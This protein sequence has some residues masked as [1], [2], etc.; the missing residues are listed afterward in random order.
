MPGA[1]L[2]LTMAFCSSAYSGTMSCFVHPG[3]Y[4]DAPANG[5]TLCW[6]N[7]EL[8]KSAR[9]IE[10]EM[11]L[12]YMCDPSWYACSHL[13][14]FEFA[15][16]GPDGSYGGYQFVIDS[17]YRVTPQSQ[18]CSGASFLFTYD[19]TAKPLPAHRAEGKNAGAPCAGEC[20]GD[21]VNAATGNHYELATDYVGAGV[22]PLRFDRHYNSSLGARS[23]RAGWRWN[24]TYERSVVEDGTSAAVLR[25]TGRVVYFEEVGG[26]WIGDADVPDRL[27]RLVDPGGQPVGWTYVDDNDSVEIYDNNGALLSIT[28]REGFI[29]SLT[30]DG[31]DRLAQVTG[32]FGRTLTFTYD[33]DG[34]WE[35]MT[36]PAGNVYTYAYNVHGNLASVTYPD[37]TPGDPGD[38]PSRHYHYA[39]TVNFD[40]LTGITDENGILYITWAYDA[41]GR[42]IA[43]SLAG[44]ADSVTLAYDDVAG[45]TTLTDALGEV[46]TF[47]FE[48]IH[49]R[50]HVATVSGAPCTTGC[51]SRFADYT[52]DAN[53]HPASRTD[54]NG[55]VTTLVYD[56]R[57]LE[58]SR[59]EAVGSPQERT[60][61]TEWHAVLRLP[62]LVTEPGK[63][64]AFTYDAQGRLLTRTETDT[65]SGN[66]RTRTNTYNALGLV[67]THDGPRNDV[68][69]VTTIDYD[70]QGNVVQS[71]NALGHVS[72]VTAYDPHGHPLTLVDAN[73]LVTTL[74]YD[75][76]RRLT[77]RDVGGST[78][79]F[80]YD[81]VGNVIRTILPDGSALFSE[82]DDAHRLV[83]IEDSL[84]NRTEFVL[85][86]AGN[87]VGETVKDSAASITRTRTR[88][89]NALNRLTKEIGGAG[90]VVDFQ[91]DLAGNQSAVTDG[92]GARTTREYDGLNRLAKAIDPASGETTLGYDARDNL[93]SV[94]D[95]EGLTTTYVYNGLDD[96]SSQTSPDTGVTTFT[97]DDA[98]NRL[99][100]VDA[101]GVVARSNYDA[102]N[103]LVSITYPD[104]A[105]NIDFEYDLGPNGLGR[106]TR[107]TD[108]SGSTDFVYDVRGNLLSEVRTIDAVAYTTAYTYDGAD[109]VLTIT[110]PSGTV[111]TYARDALGRVEHVTSTTGGVMETL[112][113]NISYLPFGP[114]E[115]FDFGNGIP[116]ARTFDQDYRLTTQIAGTVQNLALGY[117]HANNITTL[118]DRLDV[119]RSQSFAYD[120]LSRLTHGEG[121]Y[122]IQDYSYD[123]IGN[124]LTLDSAAG[125]DTYSYGSD[126]H[127]LEA[128]AGANPAS[129]TYDAN[130]NTVAKGPLSFTYD[131]TNRM[132]EALASGVVVGEY[133]YNGKGERVKK[134]AAGGGTS[135]KL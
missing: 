81:G 97:H 9:L 66:S 115:G 11:G 120:N 65:V 118:A 131:D 73:G 77:R 80:E 8:P 129:F 93:I 122:G 55:N 117:D 6:P 3:D 42:V 78:T 22:F 2:V 57:G 48:T 34:Q 27:E 130:G 85:D 41:K 53:G 45:T 1:V 13:S 86:A 69:D 132:T 51:G 47:S 39:D 113:S 62:E 67:A 133:V 102:L 90:Q 24:H 84:G 99:T 106:V 71:T 92:N 54:H 74:V 82:Y 124:R 30:Y 32:P 21:P 94:T 104:P 5:D 119:A 79:R 14:G 50:M 64:T 116:L 18:C 103:R 70:A 10:Q 91:Y 56:A 20:V 40:V 43:N 89:F 17:Q 112:A 134:T 7:A 49:D 46:R 26:A 61:T 63:T 72:R 88:V 35:T 68:T 87:R 4:R 19:P 76:R 23:R 36:D 109:R 125:F 126:S 25:E 98:G 75:A 83:A 59:T 107:M 128:I 28:T 114:M 33:T 38:N 96:L 123:G 15:R 95:A 58:I 31:A 105:K 108:A 101:R 60:I 29:Q 111:V 37:E 16:A 127:R 12:P 52:T 44:G 135:T 100:Q 110:Y 121:I